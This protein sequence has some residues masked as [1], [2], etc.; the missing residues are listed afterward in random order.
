MNCPDCGMGIIDHSCEFCGWSDVK[1]KTVF[2]SEEDILNL[3]NAERRL[4]KTATPEYDALEVFTIRAI[5]EKYEK[6]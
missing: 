1:G 4:I 6:E 3:K 5:I 2:V